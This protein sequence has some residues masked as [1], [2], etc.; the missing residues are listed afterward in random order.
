METKTEIAALTEAIAGSPGETDLYMDRG[1]LYLQCNDFGNALND[2]LRAS[3]LDPEDPEPREYITMI[4]E[5]LEF[6][7]TD[8]YNP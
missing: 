2:F 4:R 6:R 5:I 1:R 3:E 7:C 8:I